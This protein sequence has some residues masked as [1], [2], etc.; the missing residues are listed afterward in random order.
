MSEDPKPKKERRRG[1]WLFQIFGPPTVKG[2]I[3][4]HSP[5]AREAWKRRVEEERAARRRK[6]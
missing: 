5:E 3:Q 1:A 2:A 6:A 4:G